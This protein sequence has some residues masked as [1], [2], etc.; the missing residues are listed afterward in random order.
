MTHLESER[1]RPMANRRSGVSLIELMIVLAILG[2]LSAIVSLV[3]RQS[4][5]DASSADS[6]TLSVVTAARQHAL[7]AGSR[8][9]VAVVVRDESVRITA[10]PDGRV[11]GAALIGIDEL[12][13]RVRKAGE[14]PDSSGSRD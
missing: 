7:Q 12:T 4:R 10:L 14:L 1:A 6:S 8:V 9:T 2:I 11:I 3:W 5:P 13:G